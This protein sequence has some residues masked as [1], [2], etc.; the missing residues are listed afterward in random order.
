MDYPSQGRIGYIVSIVQKRLYSI[1]TNA[2]ASDLDELAT[3]FSRFDTSFAKTGVRLLAISE[4]KMQ[5]L[6]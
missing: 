4:Q 5:Q 1:A 2:I 3:G 6:V